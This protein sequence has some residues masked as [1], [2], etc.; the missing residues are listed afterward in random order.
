MNN[1]V[2]YTGWIIALTLL[3]F[4]VYAQAD[5][6]LDDTEIAHVGLVANQIDVDYGQIALEK[7]DTEEVREV[8]NMMIRDH[9]NAIEQ[10]EQ[11]ADQLNVEAEEN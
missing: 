5:I 9:G 1:R 11:L 10:I 3:P 7:S 8:A 6:D 4:S 2:S